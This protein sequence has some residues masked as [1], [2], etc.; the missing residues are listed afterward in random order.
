MQTVAGGYI[1]ATAFGGVVGVARAFQGRL[2]T[3]PWKTILGEGE[4]IAPA[5][6]ETTEIATGAVQG[7]ASGPSNG[8]TRSFLL[9]DVG[10]RCADTGALVETNLAARISLSDVLEI[11][12][13]FGRIG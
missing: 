10:A 3:R 11:G 5:E 2:Q 13:V 1:G 6:L 9:A 12:L 7:R 4:H 8:T